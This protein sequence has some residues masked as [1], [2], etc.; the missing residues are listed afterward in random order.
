MQ[1]RITLVPF[2][3]IG[4]RISAIESAVRLSKA[5]G[6]EL[7]VMWFQ[8][9]GMKAAFSDLFS[10]QVPGLDVVDHPTLFDRISLER[11]RKHNLYSSAPFQG[12][13]FDRCFYGDRR[14]ISSEE[15]LDAGRV[16]ITSCYSFFDGETD[17]SFFSPSNDVAK[18][19]SELTYGFAE[20]TV[21]IHVRRG[22]HIE[23]TSHSPISLFMDAIENEP[24][25]TKFYLSTDSH[26]VKTAL[27]EKYGNRIMTDPVTLQRG[28]M[29]AECEAVAELF[30]LSKC[31]KVIGS[32]NSSFGLKSAE[33][34]RIPFKCISND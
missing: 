21:G 30:V 5:R 33:I 31:S 2:G 9:W 3:G 20:N 29:E 14:Y 13:I 26:Q 1:K 23:A 7:R 17:Y 24:D 8:D 15:L 10:V 32:F 25:G 27:I 6:Y 28:S 16:Y 4:N 12:M 34:G 19:V 11:P 18:R 22:D